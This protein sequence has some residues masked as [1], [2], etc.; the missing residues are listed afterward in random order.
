V[1]W[2]LVGIT[3]STTPGRSE[4]TLACRALT[5]PRFPHFFKNTGQVDIQSGTLRLIGGSTSAGGQFTGAGRLILGGSTTHLLDADTTVSIANVEFQNGTTTL[6]G[7]YNVTG[8]TR[9]TGGVANL[10]GPVTGVGTTLTL[11]SGLLNLGSNS[12]AVDVL[13]HNSGLEG[14]G[15]LTVRTP[16]AITFGDMR[17]P[18]TTILQNGGAISVS[19][20]MLDGGRTLRNEGTL[21]WSAGTIDLNSNLGFSGNIM[22]GA[23]TIENIA[24]ARFVAADGN[25]A[26]RSSNWGVFDN[27]AVGVFNNAGTLEK[28]GSGALIVS[29]VLNNTGTVQ[30]DTG[31]LRL[32][33]GGTSTGGRFSGTGT[34]RFGGGTYTTDA[35]TTISTS[36]VTFAGGVAN[37]A[38]TY[39]VPGTTMVSGGTVNFSGNSISGGSSLLVTGGTAN[40]RHQGNVTFGSVENSGGNL[41]IDQP[42]SLSLAPATSYV[43]QSASGTTVVNGLLDAVLVDVR[44]G[45]LAGSGEIRGAV[46]NAGELRPGGTTDDAVTGG[47]TG[48]LTVR[49]DYTQLTSGLLSI[50]IGGRTASSEYDV[51]SIDG[52]AF[53]SGTLGISLLD[54]FTPISGDS[55]VVSH[56]ASHVGEHAFFSGFF[57]GEFLQFIPVY[58]DHSLML[59]VEAKFF[60]TIGEAPEAPTWA[61]MAI[62]LL[63][64]L[65]QRIAK[66]RET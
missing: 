12:V 11:Q 41:V 4:R 21:L 19:G 20:L 56:Y 16:A 3:F 14:S 28:S 59:R 39:S 38:G 30:V 27:G 62:G 23:G 52:I 40:F 60:P 15:I 6:L 63:V 49:G 37:I 29:A 36:S 42:S 7:N 31:I 26:L 51:L 46:T 33:G 48:Q 55:F 13:N 64:L 61:M 58:S 35:A 8:S 65:C 25:L 18:G 9:I 54:G 47:K 44:A 2:R 45:I 24:G 1:F 50:G 57:I 53:F 10:L 22:P 17:G 66:C 5:K 32:D 43:Q 34:L